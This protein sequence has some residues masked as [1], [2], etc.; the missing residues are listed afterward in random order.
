MADWVYSGILLWRPRIEL[1]GV[2]KSLSRKRW[3]REI[4]FRSKGSR[5]FKTTKAGG[6]TTPERT[7]PVGALLRKSR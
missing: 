5:V 4:N 3:P 2:P 7:G 1:A 6:S